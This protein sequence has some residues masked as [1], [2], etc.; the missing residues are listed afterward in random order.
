M[1]EDVLLSEALSNIRED[2]KKVKNL[3]KELQGEIS[4]ADTTHA[5]SGVV[6]AKYVE[7]LQ[8]SNEQLVKI[9]AMLDKNKKEEEDTTLSSEE[10]DS[11]FELIK[12][13]S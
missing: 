1:K 3:L 5:R 11:I 8:R 2:R 13:V 10:K 9:I 6:A 12:E 7:T 4:S